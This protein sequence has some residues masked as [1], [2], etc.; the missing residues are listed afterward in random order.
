PASLVAQAVST[1]QI[2]LIWGASSDNIGVT[3]YNV[4]RNGN[5]LT[6]VTGTTFGDSTLSP[7]TSYS[8]VVKAR[9]AAGNIS[10]SS[11]TATAITPAQIVNGSIA[12]TVTTPPGAGIC[13]VKISTLLASGRR[14]TAYTNCQGQY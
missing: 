2:N 10:G 13:N 7:S 5:L 11:N 3:G 6:T 8:Y 1:S 14:N 12:G 4:Y 9:D